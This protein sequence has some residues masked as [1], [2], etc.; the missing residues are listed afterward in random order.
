M[1][2]LTV[3][4]RLT[5]KLPF[6]LD[7]L[8]DCLTITDLRSADVCLHLELSEHSVHDNVEV[9]FTHTCDDGLSRFLVGIRFESGVFLLQ[10]DDSHIHSLLACFRFRFDCDLDNGVGENHVFE[11][12][13]VV[14]V[15][16]RVARSALLQADNGND[17]SRICFV[18][19]FA[20]VRIHTKD[21]ADSFVFTLD[22]VVNHRARRKSSRIDADEGKFSD[23]LIR[24]DLKHE[25]AERFFFAGVTE[26]GLT[27]LWIDAFDTR[28]VRR[29]GKE[30]DH[31]VEHKLYARVLVRTSAK[32][33]IEFHFNRALTDCGFEF[34]QRN[35]IVILHDDFFKDILVKVCRRLEHF[36]SVFFCKVLILGR[37]FFCVERYAFILLVV[38]ERL[39]REK[40]DDSLEIGLFSDRQRDGDCVCVQ[41]FAHH[42]DSVEEVRTV[43][44]H[45]VDE[46]DSRHFIRVCLT[47]HV[48]GL[49]F[50]AALGAEHR[51][52]SVENSQTAFDLNREV[53]VSGGVDDVYLM[54]FPHGSGCCRSDC[55]TSFSLLLHVIHS[56]RAVVSL[57]QFSVH[58]RVI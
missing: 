25:S 58:A 12:D 32:N 55:D 47:P 6:C 10:L 16:K 7:S 14:F 39:H 44:V 21:T 37:D 29:S 17:I 42:F 41:S 28:N 50:D 40:I 3:T 26:F 52:R 5:H 49:R 56:S 2:V 20:V 36:E 11:N 18:D 33:G 1:A 51:D 4:A 34:F 23:K 48:F 24:E 53:D 57:A 35:R 46:S 45:F 13:L 27:G 31:R 8:R 9:K 19:I 54:S 30:V 38:V 43:D 15:G 22:G